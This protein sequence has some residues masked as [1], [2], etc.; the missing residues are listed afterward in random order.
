MPFKALWNVAPDSLLIWCRPF[1][2][3]VNTCLLDGD[4]CPLLAPPPSSATLATPL[5]PEDFLPWKYLLVTKLSWA[6]TNRCF[7]SL[8]VWD[9]CHHCN[10]LS[11]FSALCC[12]IHFWR[13]GRRRQTTGNIFQWR[14]SFVLGSYWW[15]YYFS[16]NGLCAA[17]PE[18][19]FWNRQR[20]C[21]FV[22]WN[23]S[24]GT[25]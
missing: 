18:W 12:K 7:V 5:H 4:P 6:V 1:R 20:I 3:R 23:F 24:V 9:W 19:F 2:P 10:G 22:R 25:N 16:S 11:G 17:T 13:H 15:S 14:K 8:F 21:K